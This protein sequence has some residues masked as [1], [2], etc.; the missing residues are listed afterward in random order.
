MTAAVVLEHEASYIDIAGAVQYTVAH[1]SRTSG[2]AA[3]A[4]NLC[5]DILLRIHAVYHETVACVDRV[6]TA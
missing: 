2:T 6:N 4:D 1:S 5:G 3:A